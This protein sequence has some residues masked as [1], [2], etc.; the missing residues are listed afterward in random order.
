MALKKLLSRLEG[1]T[2]TFRDRNVDFIVRDLEGVNE[3]LGSKI[4]EAPIN[5]QEYL[6]KD[7]AWIAGG[8]GDLNQWLMSG[9]AF[10]DP[11]NGDNI[12]ATVGDGNL[13]YKTLA[14]AQVDS[15]YVLAMAGAYQFSTQGS[16]VIPILDG[17]HIHFMLGA[18]TGHN[19]SI[20]DNGL[21]VTAFITGQLICGTNSYGFS[22][23][24][25]ASRLH[26]EMEAM[27]NTRQIIHADN[28][29]QVS[30]IIKRIDCNNSTGSGYAC[31]VW[32]DSRITLD[33]LE[34]CYARH[35]LAGE[36]AGAGGPCY[37]TINCPDLR[38]VA[39]NTYGNQY[40]SLLNC[41]SY[42]HVIFTI[43]VGKFTHEG[44]SQTVSFG[45]Q[46]SAMGLYTGG[47]GSFPNEFHFTGDY[48]AG[49]LYGWFDYNFVYEGLTTFKDG[50]VKSETLAFSSIAVNVGPIVIR[51][52]VAKNF[53]FE[54]GLTSDGYNQIGNGRIASFVNCSFKNNNVA[55]TRIFNHNNAVPSAGAP[56]LYLYNCIGDMDNAGAGELIGGAVL[57]FNFA[58]VN[59]YSSE[60]IGALIVDAWLGYT[61][62]VGFKIPKF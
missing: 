46:D 34:Y 24:G 13:P 30:M 50:S 29:S 17:K 51:T 14:A 7:G 4:S 54:G 3:E 8:G 27:E 41:Q 9:V 2:K 23:T 55:G 26:V 16:N 42:G 49:K 62:I 38:I 47:A 43:N 22:F 57:P 25:G 37:F 5:G 19:S 58:S 11:T 52:I 6:R 1:K 33:V 40:K 45:T 28:G 15:D 35:W 60:P 20:R 12:T 31:R 39:A 10:V 56:F 44:T 61:Q 36:G 48:D 21:D 18:I 59:T 32:D 53:N